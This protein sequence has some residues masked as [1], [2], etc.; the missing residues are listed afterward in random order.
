MISKAAYFGGTYNSEAFT[1]TIAVHPSAGKTWRLAGSSTP[2]VQMHDA[3][4]LKVDLIA[5]IS[6]SGANLITVKDA[7][8]GTI[9]TIASGAVKI[10]HL[11][12]TSTQAGVW[13]LLSR[14]FL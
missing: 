10:L 14:S 7:A 8:G 11:F 4:T 1:G 13:R 9:G 5:A 3:R 12:D 6:N 2:V